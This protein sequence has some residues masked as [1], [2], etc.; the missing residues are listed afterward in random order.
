MF[1]VLSVLVTSA[2]AQD[3]AGR[4][5]RINIIVEET[6]SIEKRFSIR[7]CEKGHVLECLKLAGLNCGALDGVSG[8]TICS[9]GDRPVYRVTYD[10]L[11]VLQGKMPRKWIVDNLNEQSLDGE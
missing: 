1:F 4:Q 5:E 9:A 6:R 2:N 3:D 7:A 8:Q 10:G 11:T